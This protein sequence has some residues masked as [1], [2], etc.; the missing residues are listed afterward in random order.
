MVKILEPEQQTQ[1]PYSMVD[2]FNMF[3]STTLLELLNAIT[4]PQINPKRK[5][6]FWCL[7]IYQSQI[8]K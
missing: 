6:Y 5:F 3:Q 1:T 7:I 2:R 4:E 8:A